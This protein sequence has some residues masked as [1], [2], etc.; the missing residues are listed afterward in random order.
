MR[1][2]S[3]TRSMETQCPFSFIDILRATSLECVQ[4]HS[5]SVNQLAA[6]STKKRQAPPKAH[7]QAL[8]LNIDPT[9]SMLRTRQGQKQEESPKRTTEGQ[10]QR[11]VQGSTKRR[12]I[13]E[14]GTSR[15]EGPERRRPT[16]STPSSTPAD[17]PCAGATASAPRRPPAPSTPPS[18]R[19][20][21]PAPRAAGPGPATPGAPGG[22]RRR[23]PWTDPPPPDHPRPPRRCSWPCPSP[24]PPLCNE[25]RSLVH[26]VRRRRWSGWGMWVAVGPRALS[27]LVSYFFW[28]APY[29]KDWPFGT[30]Q[31]REWDSQP[32]PRGKW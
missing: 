20:P 11:T 15:E 22:A 21:A 24:S 12:L 4:A 25:H 32:P 28:F 13:T 10:K 29:V 1:T 31:T 19:A 23:L 6:I 14:K 8:P 16:R 18:G 27:L 9:S 7:F 26:F 3:K 17:A 2:R 30:W 5:T